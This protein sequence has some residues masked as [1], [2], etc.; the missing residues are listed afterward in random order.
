MFKPYKIILRGGGGGRV[1]AERRGH[2]KQSARLTTPLL[3]ASI[4]KSDF[5]FRDWGLG[6]RDQGFGVGV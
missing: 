5:G 1:E 4:L 6:F 3:E 2:R